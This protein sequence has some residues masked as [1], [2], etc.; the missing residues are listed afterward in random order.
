MSRAFL[1]TLLLVLLTTSCGQPALPEAKH[2]SNEP[3]DLTFEPND[4]GAPFKAGRVALEYVLTN[5]ETMPPV[6]LLIGANTA[7]GLER[8]E[9]AAFLLYAAW[10]RSK[11]DLEKYKPTKTGGDSPE[12]YL[13]FLFHNIGEPVNREI[14]LQP[15]DYAA[16]ME[17]L[18]AWT[19]KDPPGYDCGWEHTLQRVPGDLS[20]KVKAEYLD[21]HKPIATLLNIPEY[22]QAFKA[23]R[24]YED[25]PLA[26]RSD[27]DALKRRSSARETMRRIEKEKNLKGLGQL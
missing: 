17:R 10:I 14:F 5:A 7:Y 20:N 21:F 22:F 6:L 2:G 3:P 18:E 27:P 26:K 16:V 15:K 4:I 1:T 13:S 24:E 19:I 12:V 23:M 25:L 9:D 11:Y 8:L